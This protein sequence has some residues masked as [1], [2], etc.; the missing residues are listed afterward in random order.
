MHQ[1]HRVLLH[2]RT[3]CKDLAV[4]AERQA[5]NSCC[6]VRHLAQRHRRRRSH[7]AVTPRGTAT[8][9]RCLAR[10]VERVE[11]DDA[12]AG[13]GGKQPPIV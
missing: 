9:R 4:G 10:R 2:A 13:A 8:R 11:V 12:A 6:Q 1:A 5:V 7:W 3:D